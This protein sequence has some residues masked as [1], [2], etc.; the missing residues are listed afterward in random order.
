MSDYSLEAIAQALWQAQESRVAI[1][2]VADAIHALTSKG[3]SA[4]ET[5]YAIQRMNAER[6][7]TMGG[8]LIGRKIG[9]TS[10]VVQQQLGV[11]EPDFGA[12]FAHMA[13]GCSQELDTNAWIQ[14]KIEAEIALVLERDLCAERH[15]FA[16]LISATAYVLPAIEIVDS[17]IE[18]WKISLL[19]TVADNASS[20][21]LVLG[22]RPVSLRDVELA[23]CG[24]VMSRRG[25]QISVGA[26]AACLGNPLNAA[27]WLADT[28]VKLGTPLQAGDIL[29]TGALGPM[30]TV[31]AGDAVTVDIE[32]L[33]RVSACFG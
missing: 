33:G 24:M 14:P 26:G 8:R 27:V 30:A 25:D 9:L 15:S 19:D 20:A 6:Q 2:P 32:G 17:R 29:L 5:A 1:P 11:N 22:S 4:L 3:Q 31:Q 23:R 13:Y 12:L 18:N 28:M 16:D 21:A 10:T 7:L